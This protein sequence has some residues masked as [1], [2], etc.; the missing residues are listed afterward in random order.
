MAGPILS[1][2]SIRPAFRSPRGARFA[3][4]NLPTE[5]IPAKIR[6]LKISGE[7]P[8]DMRTPPLKSKMLLESNPL[9]SRIVVRRLGVPHKSLRAS[10]SLALSELAMRRGP[11]GQFSK[12]KS[13]KMGPAPGRF[14]LSRDV[15]M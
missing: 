4:P 8:L 9:K 7:F 3:A 5:I 2:R 10:L 11:Y 1:E 6:W 12:V 13:G 15:L 14:E